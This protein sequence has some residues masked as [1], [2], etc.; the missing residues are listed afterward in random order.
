MQV[1]QENLLL[2]HFGCRQVKLVILMKPADV[3]H[4]QYEQLKIIHSPIKK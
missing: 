1:T 4:K 2:I 3:S